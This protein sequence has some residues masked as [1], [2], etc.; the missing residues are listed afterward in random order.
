MKNLL[1]TFTAA[2]VA[3]S[4]V[5]L[6]HS[7]TIEWGSEV[8]SNFQQS[9]GDPLDSSFVFELGAFD[10]AFSPTPANANDW[11]A[12]WQVFDVADFNPITNYFTSTVDMNPTGGSTSPDGNPSFDFQGLQAYMWIRNE[13][14]P[15]PT[16]EWFLAADPTWIY[17]TALDDCCNNQPPL[18]WVINS[19]TPPGDPII[20]TQVPEPT[21]SLFLTLAATAALLRRK[22]A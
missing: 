16:A 22:R 20:L 18:Q 4:S 5:G 6:A 21:G 2:V 8:F 7:Q 9:N 12:N 15:S 10:N 1:S 17:P 3:L 19:V 14:I 11:F 13:D